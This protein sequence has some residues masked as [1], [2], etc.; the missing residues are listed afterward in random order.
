MSTRRG[1]AVVGLLLW[2]SLALAGC[3]FILLE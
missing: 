3:A 1:T 2:I